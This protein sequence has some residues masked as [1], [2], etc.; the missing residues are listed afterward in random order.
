MLYRRLLILVAFVCCAVGGAY[1]RTYYLPDYQSVFQ[2]DGRTNAVSEERPDSPTCATYGYQ[3]SILENSEC[4]PVRISGFGLDCYS[5]TACS[6]DYKYEYSSSN[7][8]GDYVLAGVSC[9]GKYSEC[10]CDSSI[11]PAASEGGC[12]AGQKVDTTQSCTNKS[13]ENKFYK[14]V[15]DE[16]Y[17]LTSQTDCEAGGGHCIAS[18]TCTGKC[19]QCMEFCAWK[20]Q[21]GA[22][23]CEYGCEETHKI[24]GCSDL[25]EAGGCKSKT[26]D[27]G[28]VLS[29]DTCIPNPCDGYPYTACPYNGICD[30][31]CKS[32]DLVKYKIT[33]CKQGYEFNDSG[34]ACGIRRCPTGFAIDGANCGS[35]ANGKYTL[36][37]N[38]N[39]YS[40]SIPC[41]NCVVSCNDGYKLNS[42]GTACELAGCRAGYAMTVEGCGTAPTGGEWTLTGT[43]TCKK[44]TETCLP[45]YAT[46]VA[47]CGNKPLNG[48]WSLASVGA[49]SCKLCVADCDAGFTTTPAWRLLEVPE[50]DIFLDKCVAENPCQDRAI[51]LGVTEEKCGLS[52]I[53]RGCDCGGY[54]LGEM[55]AD[56]GSGCMI[57]S[58][59]YQYGSSSSEKVKILC[60]MYAP[61]EYGYCT[62]K[63]ELNVTSLETVLNDFRD[64][65]PLRRFTFEGFSGLLSGYMCMH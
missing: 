2:Y 54:N 16:C 33:E 37:S 17:A 49:G 58:Y 41:K 1:A 12:P 48:Q 57:L 34:L 52:F 29:D 3:D 26:C 27:E 45:R 64:I 25:C 28:Y 11:F 51:A 53:S 18:D 44:C 7:C 60:G 50:T 15:E 20:E 36:G 47:E 43:G 6:S 35:I 9:G 8:S 55:C 21:E 40:G 56:G 10:I 5:C 61:I 13:D 30:E 22:V 42:A 46:T 19:D 31:T 63:E 23:R 59:D 32:G 38:T 24:S 62:N 14:C 65:C 39:G 4:T